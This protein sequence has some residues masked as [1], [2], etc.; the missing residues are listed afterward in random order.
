[1]LA[2]LKFLNFLYKNFV[3]HMKKCQMF[4]KLDIIKKLRQA[5][6]RARERYQN[7][8]EGEKTGRIC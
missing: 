5:T 4:H 1:M 6:K 8:S 7:L 2:I 3:S